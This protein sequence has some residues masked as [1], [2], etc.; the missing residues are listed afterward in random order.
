MR[1]KA[2]KEF[3]EQ[4]HSNKSKGEAIGKDGDGFS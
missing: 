3:R 2:K 4:K 1:T